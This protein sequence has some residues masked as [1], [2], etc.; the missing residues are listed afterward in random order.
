MLCFILLAQFYLLDAL[1]QLATH[2]TLLWYH[3]PSSQ[4]FAL[5]HHDTVYTATVSRQERMTLYFPYE[6]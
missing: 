3:I 4:S 5:Y 6:E 2:Q 1:D